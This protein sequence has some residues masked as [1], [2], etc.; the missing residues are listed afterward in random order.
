MIT[1]EHQEG[2]F[3]FVSG[4][5]RRQLWCPQPP[6]RSPAP[7]HRSK[8]DRGTIVSMKPAI[9]LKRIV[10]KAPRRPA[11]GKNGW[12]W[13]A[14]WRFCCWQRFPAAPCI[15]RSC[16]FPMFRAPTTSAPT[17]ANVPRQDLPG[18]RHRRPCAADGP[19]NQRA[20]RRVRILSRP[21]QPARGF[22]RRHETALQFHLRPAADQ[23]LRRAVR[24]RTGA[25]GGNGLLSM[26]CRCAR[27]VQ[28]A[29]PSSGARGPT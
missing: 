6:V 1:N 8:L 24:G 4:V 12:R 13:R 17:S 11:L 7:G 23:Q 14:G 2:A 22:G 9:I 16:S 27:P 29:Q 28:P 19:G 18:L 25:L 10:E 21:L 15:V 20:G 3:R 26:P 5:L